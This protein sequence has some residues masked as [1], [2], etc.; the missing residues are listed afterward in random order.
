MKI[1]YVAGQQQ[2]QK[3][4]AADCWS[5]ASADAENYIWHSHMRCW[6]K[7]KKKKHIN[8][9]ICIGGHIEEFQL[10]P[11]SSDMFSKRAG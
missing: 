2:Q 7:K 10:T 8:C 5:R 9:Y 6:E 1:L 11:L 4:A 3:Q